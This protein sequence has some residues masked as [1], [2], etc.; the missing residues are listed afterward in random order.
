MPRIVN[1]Y[2]FVFSL[3]Q[4][5]TVHNGAIIRSRVDRHY[6]SRI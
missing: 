4:R 3:G 2:R 6:G 5:Y 1:R